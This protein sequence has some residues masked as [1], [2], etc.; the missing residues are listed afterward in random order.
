MAANTSVK[1]VLSSDT[2]LVDLVHAASESMAGV[3][4]LEA[5][6]ALNLGLAVREAVINAILHGNGQDPARQVT[7]TLTARWD[8]LV[9]RVSDQ[10]GGFDPEQTP[11]PRN[12]ANL[13]RETGRGL[14]LM[15][16]FVDSVRFR[17][18]PRGGTQV[19][20]IKR[21]PTGSA[22]GGKRIS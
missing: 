21:I 20:M 9:A 17:A 4:G 8:K 15:Q 10:G 3:A 7:V 5:D 12:G 14:L 16:A 18:L 11:D 6:E 2:K 22:G 19:T 1:L 13:L